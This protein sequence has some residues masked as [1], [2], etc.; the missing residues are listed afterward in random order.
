MKNRLGRSRLENY[1]F[2][3]V[4]PL[5]GLNVECFSLENVFN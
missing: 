4:V 1:I 3:A 2:F 5:I